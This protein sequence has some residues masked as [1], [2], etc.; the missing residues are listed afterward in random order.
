[1]TGPLRALAVIQARMSSTRLPGK[2]LA[3]LGSEPLL[4]L[5]VSR[6]KRA[7]RLERILIATSGES[8][9]DRIAAL[10]GP[11]EVDIHRGPRDDVLTRFAEAIGEHRGT[12]VRITGD[13]PLIDPDVVNAVID[14]LEATPGCGYASNVEP[15]T[16]PDGLDVEAFPA[17]ALL[18]VAAEARDPADREHVTSAIRRDPE[19]WPQASLTEGRDL[20]ELR[21][22]V[23][24][25]ADL[26]FI[27]QVVGRLGE[28]RYE[29]GLEEIRDAILAEPSLADFGGARRA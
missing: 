19:R 23:D 12:V 17:E 15:R 29:A 16:Y 6:L 5:L 22:T 13:C 21:W 11:L 7:G 8:E 28:R 25:E 20:A 10:A 3:D 24:T 18:T 9:D 1:L 26:E 4:S 27:R 2:T 14:L